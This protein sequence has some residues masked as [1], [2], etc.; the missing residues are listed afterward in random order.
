MGTKNKKT[1]IEGPGTVID[2][3]PTND[4]RHQINEAITQIS[5]IRNLLY[6]IS[7]NDQ[8]LGDMFDAKLMPHTDRLTQIA[9]TLGEIYGYTVADDLLSQR[10]VR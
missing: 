5:S 8:M 6:F 7:E 3:I 2:R 10:E 9:I 1:E 4:L